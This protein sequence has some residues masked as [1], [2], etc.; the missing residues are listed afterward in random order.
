MII[1][2]LK[3]NQTIPSPVC[4]SCDTCCH[5]PSQDSLM[6][7][8]FTHKERKRVIED[9]FSPDLF[10]PTDDGKSSRI[11]L[12]AYDKMFICPAFLPEKGECSIY[13][14]RPLDCQIYPFVMTFDENHKQV[15]LCI[16]EICPYTEIEISK[17]YRDSSQVVAFLESDTVMLEIA[18]NWSLVGLR[19]E[20]ATVIC[21]LDRL[22]SY[23]T[24]T[25]NH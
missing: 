4:V 7:P 13:P 1:K 8:I 12:R 23:L 14:I 20:T 17:F 2:K 18:E 15:L 16:D 10:G 22:T 3:L 19:L 9:G 25:I 24:Q 11:Q 21:T 5:F 6:A